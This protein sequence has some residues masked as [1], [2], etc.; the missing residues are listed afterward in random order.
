MACTH[1]VRTP[2]TWKNQTHLRTR[3][4]RFVWRLFGRL[5]ESTTSVGQH[6]DTDFNFLFKD[7]YANIFTTEVEPKLKGQGLSARDRRVLVTRIVAKAHS[8][9]NV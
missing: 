2:L 8:L 7:N 5:K 3:I 1:S 4:W 9:T 6:L